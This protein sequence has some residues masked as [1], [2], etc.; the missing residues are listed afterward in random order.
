MPT[1]PHICL[2]AH[3][4]A[5]LRSVAEARDATKT[6]LGRRLWEG[7]RSRAEADLDRDPFTPWSEFPER[8]PIHA[9]HRNA[10]YTVCLAA[11]QRILRASLV[12]LLTGEGAFKDEALRQMASLFDPADWPMWCDKAHVHQGSPP[13]DLRTGMLC[14]DLAL[15]YD[16]LHGSLSGPD[17]QFIIEGIDRCGIQPYL[18]RL[19]G[20]PFWL[21]SRHNWTTC[22]VGG[23]G[24]AGMAL[25]DDHPDSGRL[26]DI[27]LP[28]M[29]DCLS[30]YGPE[31]EFNESVGYAGAIQLLVNFYAAWLYQTD[32][33]ENLLASWPFPEACRWVMHFTNPPGYGVPFGDAHR[34]TPV[35]SQYFA[36][37]AAATRDPLLQWFFATHHETEQERR[38]DI[39]PFLFF[40]D[41]LAAKAPGPGLPLGRA[42]HAHGQC[43]SS[44]TDWNPRTTACVVTGKAGREVNHAHNDVGQL[45]I[46]GYGEPLIV[47][48]GAC[49]YP[50]HEFYDR[51]ENFYNFSGSGHNIPM[52]GERDL[53]MTPDAQGRIEWARFD[54]DL[55]AC[56]RLD[57]TAAY[58]GVYRVH[59]T[60]IHLF[61]GIVAVSDRIDLCHPE[62]VVL[63]WHTADRST[64]SPDGSFTVTGKSARLV[65]KI[66]RP[67]RGIL[68]I[69]RGEHAYQPPYDRNR[70]GEH[71]V[72]KHESFIEVV[73]TGEKVRLISLFAVFPG[74]SPLPGW[75]DPG[76]GVWAIET[77]DGSI[78]VRAGAEGFT[79][80]NPGRGSRIDRHQ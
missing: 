45:C 67:D 13:A 72:Q 25:A 74:G 53:R 3:K 16:W 57:T 43:I 8:E 9:R 71:L 2:T 46:D 73:T 59:R 42:Y 17:R 24:I 51:L 20:K 12:H 40:D 33:R 11:G 76:G 14:A 31:G 64:P 63:R 28:V 65:G 80:A 6:G 61:P 79:A 68:E 4:T 36:A 44:R 50:S 60:V 55:G 19:P 34:E 38:H 27:A 29:R 78:E 70:L 75:T 77:P 5:Q 39:R 15:A 32:G 52:I 23:L 7:I 69:R 56:W 26:I 47:D 22:V 1:R 30:V 48:L 41:T 10:D 37:V 54:R 18:E 21:T 35:A 49:H 58:E 62:Q 66:A